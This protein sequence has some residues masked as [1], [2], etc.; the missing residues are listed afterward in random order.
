MRV[1]CS[2][3]GSEVDSSAK[4][5]PNCGSKIIEEAFIESED[6]HYDIGNS[7]SKKYD[8]EVSAKRKKKA[9]IY[10]V[11]ALISLFILI[12]NAAIGYTLDDI[13]IGALFIIISTFTL[14]VTS[15]FSLVYLIGFTKSTVIEGHTITLDYAN[16]TYVYLDGKCISC[17]YYPNTVYVNLPSGTKIA[18]IPKFAYGGRY[19]RVQDVDFVK[20][21]KE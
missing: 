9:A 14:L 6:V 16:R 10:G 19:N 15:I 12:I 11:I 8:E 7:F 21:C 18:V 5:C 2:Y 20:V 13:G 3:C 17:T 1:R 4:F